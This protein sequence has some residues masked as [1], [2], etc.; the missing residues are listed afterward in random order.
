MLGKSSKMG[1]PDEVDLTLSRS[2]K[3]HLTALSL[4]F[5]V[6]LNEFEMPVF[7][8]SIQPFKYS[9][10]MFL[11]PSVIGDGENSSITF[12]TEFSCQFRL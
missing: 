2:Y 7:G 5:Y 4:S 6:R 10:Y 3:S 12:C 9:D 1:K 11:N 8:F